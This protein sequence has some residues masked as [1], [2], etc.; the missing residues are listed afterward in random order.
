MAI[1]EPQGLTASA[2]FDLLWGTLADVLGSAATAILLRRAAR[3]GASHDPELHALVIRRDPIGYTY[4]VPATW[5]DPANLAPTAAIG[6][7]MSELEPLLFELTGDIIINR[8]AR[9][10]ALR[11]LAP[12]A[13]DATEDS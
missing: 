3:R 1:S 8:L 9:V 10:P 12:R 13:P 7:L 2:L 11:A 4:A 6:V 5:Q